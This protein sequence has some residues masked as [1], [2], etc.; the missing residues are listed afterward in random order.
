[1]PLP[2]L[3]PLP[4]AHR[5]Q[6]RREA[7]DDA[8]RTLVPVLVAVAVASLPQEAPLSTQAAPVPKHRKSTKKLP[9]ALSTPKTPK[10]TKQS[11]KHNQKKKKL[12]S[13]KQLPRRKEKKKKKRPMDLAQRQDP[14]FPF[15]TQCTLNN[16]SFSQQGPPG[17]VFVFLPRCMGVRQHGWLPSWQRWHFGAAAHPHCH[18]SPIPSTMEERGTCGWAARHPPPFLQGAV[19]SSDLLQTFPTH[20]RDPGLATL[21]DN[22]CSR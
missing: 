10:K 16:I 8:T 21:Q 13:L 19:G 3:P 15:P 9:R 2:A 18:R 14:C 20:W 22:I 4:P 11:K 17:P 1:M 7:P 5:L 12:A 6:G